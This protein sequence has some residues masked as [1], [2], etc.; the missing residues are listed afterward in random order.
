MT[1]ADVRKSEDDEEEDEEKKALPPNAKK[2][3]DEED[4]EA[5][6]PGTPPDKKRPPFN[7]EKADP[8]VKE[9]LAAVGQALMNIAGTGQELPQEVNDFAKSAVKLA[10]EKKNGNIIEVAKSMF[11]GLVEAVQAPLQAELG[12]L[13]GKVEQMEGEREFEEMRKMAEELPGDPEVVAKQL[14]TIKKAMTP[15]EF[16]SYVDTQRGL[17]S[18]VAKSDLFQRQSSGQPVAGSAE[19]IVMRKAQELVAKSENGVQN[20]SEAIDLVCKNDPALYARYTEE[21][22]NRR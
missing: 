16:T 15:E 10:A 18:Q 7:F 8:Q 9:A 1:K 14:V 21:Q 13:K 19:E 20:L 11:P 2:P 6:P 17:K 12:S 5:A 3:D 4:E 22:R